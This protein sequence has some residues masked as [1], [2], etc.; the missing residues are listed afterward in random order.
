MTKARAL[1]V[2]RKGLMSCSGPCSHHGPSRCE[3]PSKGQV[4]GRNQESVQDVV[5]MRR[6]ECDPVPADIH[7]AGAY[8]HVVAPGQ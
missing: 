3:G 2:I 7:N 4:S 5:F 1:G 6:Y 8:L